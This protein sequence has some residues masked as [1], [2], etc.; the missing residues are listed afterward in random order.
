MYATVRYT[1][2]KQGALMKPGSQKDFQQQFSLQYRKHRL[3]SP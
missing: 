2:Y 3:D 1:K